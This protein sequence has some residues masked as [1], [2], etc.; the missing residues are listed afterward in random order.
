MSNTTRQSGNVC[1]YEMRG[2][3]LPLAPPAYVVG[4]LTHFPSSATE[5]IDRSHMIEAE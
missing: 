1:M 3:Y 5:S 2:I 4:I